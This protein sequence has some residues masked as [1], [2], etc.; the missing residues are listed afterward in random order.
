MCII[1]LRWG[2]TDDTEKNEIF[3]DFDFGIHTE[4]RRHGDFLMRK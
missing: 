1:D 2:N 4:V 3:T